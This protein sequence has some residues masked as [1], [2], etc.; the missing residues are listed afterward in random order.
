MGIIIIGVIAMVLDRL[1]A[2]LER[3]VVPWAGKA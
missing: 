3:A 1:A 2:A